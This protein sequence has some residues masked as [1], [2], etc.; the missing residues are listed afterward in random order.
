MKKERIIWIIIVIIS[1]ITTLL[2]SGINL[3]S[4][5]QKVTVA[6]DSTAAVKKVENNKIDS[7]AK[8]IEQLKKNTPKVV[9]VQPNSRQQQQVQQPTVTVQQ[10]VTQQPVVT[11]QPT[12]VGKIR[13][14]ES[15]DNIRGLAP[16]D[17]GISARRDANGKLFI[18]VSHELLISG[19]YKMNTDTPRLATENGKPFYWD[20]KSNLWVCET[21]RYVS[22][23]DVV[24]LAIW[25][26]TTPDGRWNTFIPYEK[27]MLE[28][29]GGQG[30]YANGY[31]GFEYRIPVTSW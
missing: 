10:P 29:E 19:R 8:E 14:R 26:G 6:D 31:N 7:L 9:I 4:C 1:V 25:I 24:S 17:A 5:S 11:T 2:L 28:G 30:I 27:V 12:T 23:G 16:S 18:F 15:N 13:E 22:V 20:S 21:G 3:P